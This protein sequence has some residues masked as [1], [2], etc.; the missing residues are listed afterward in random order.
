MVN[1]MILLCAIIFVNTYGMKTRFLVGR[2]CRW[3]I[4][5]CLD[6]VLVAN[7]IQ[8]WRI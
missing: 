3:T 1:V 4:C 2:V 8:L 5:R 7:Y 6:F